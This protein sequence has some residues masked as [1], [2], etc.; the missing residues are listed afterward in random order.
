MF[1]FKT[2]SYCVAPCFSSPAS[3]SKYLN[4]RH[5]PGPHLGLKVWYVNPHTYIGGKL[6]CFS[7]RI[8]FLY[9]NYLTLLSPEGAWHVCVILERDN[10]RLTER[11]C[12]EPT[13][14]MHLLA[15]LTATRE[16]Q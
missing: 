1:S 9:M 8:G 13:V 6:E 2:R 14:P 12:K 15:A 5:V 11:L 16:E 7:S 4:Y 3:A 10:F